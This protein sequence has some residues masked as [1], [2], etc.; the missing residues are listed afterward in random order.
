MLMKSGDCI[1]NEK[2]PRT[3]CRMSCFGSTE[4]GRYEQS[5]TG[6]PPLPCDN[7]EMRHKSDV[8]CYAIYVLLEQKQ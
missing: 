5:F 6:V 4:I 7:V 1:V 2:R 3:L 8:E